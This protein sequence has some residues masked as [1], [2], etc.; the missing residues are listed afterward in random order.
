MESTSNKRSCF[1]SEAIKILVAAV[2][3]HVQ[4]ATIIRG[5]EVINW[6]DRSSRIINKMFMGPFE[7]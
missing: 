4:K 2:Y 3:Q 6:E 5:L 7:E 1:I